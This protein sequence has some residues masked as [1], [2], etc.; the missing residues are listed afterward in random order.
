M[1][2][3]E[4]VS[5]LSIKRAVNLYTI[6]L[7]LSFGILL[8]WLALDRYQVFI[9]SHE[10]RSS[11]TTKIVAFEIDKTIREKQRVVGMFVDSSY[12][13]IT[14]LT[15]NPENEEIQQLLEARLK[16]YQPDIFAFNIMT[17][18]GEPIIGDFNGDIGE[19]CLEDLRHYIK[20]GKQI[21]RMH[22]NHNENHY[23]IISKYSMN[24]SDHLF[25]VSFKVNELSRILG[26]AQSAQHSLIL[27]NK[28]AS[29]LIEVT[30]P[31]NNIK[32]TERLD[33]RMSGD[34][35]SRVL[36]STQVEDTNW[37]VID[38]R[39]DDLF[40][41]YKKKITTE[42]IIGYYIFSIIVLFMRNIL[43]KQDA[44]RT[45]AEKQLQ[46]NHKQIKDLN[47]QLETLSRTDSLTGLYNRRYFDEMI[48]QE[49]NR[50]L[51]SG[52]TLSCILLDIDY[53]KGYND[54]YGH[55]AGDKCLKDISLVMKDT[56]RRAGDVVAR[57]GGEEFIIIMSDTDAEAAETAIT[58]FQ[59][60]LG[61]LKIE[62][63]PSTINDYVTIS[64]GLASQT[65]SRDDSIEDFIRKAD[66]ALYR[67][68]DSGRNQYVVYDQSENT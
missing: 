25:F 14:E 4:P 54:F 29:N 51:R 65:P 7:F 53:F 21:I 10:D 58:F 38:L 42:Y 43:L 49:W 34:E 47:N 3:I 41:N 37:H 59:K 30:A 68:K 44:K 40:T 16:K 26:S 45:A 39:D 67:A 48:Y 20:N 63:Q 55:Q 57:Y 52:Q 2:L 50:C 22:P 5:S 66:N 15:N 46:K 61:K 56:F 35:N 17:K 33:Y 32:N 12:M 27:V 13:H 31:D 9:T 11:S 1:T 64:A 36:S 19:L 24:D 8:Y 28:D 62:Y 18:L 23:D 6:I 60:E